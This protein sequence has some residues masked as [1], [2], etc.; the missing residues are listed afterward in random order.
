MLHESHTFKTL[1]PQIYEAQKMGIGKV[2]IHLNKNSRDDTRTITNVIHVIGTLTNLLPVRR[3]VE[4]KAD[5]SFFR[6][7]LPNLS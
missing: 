7:R 2:I 1:D 4:E 6:T 3:L 5:D